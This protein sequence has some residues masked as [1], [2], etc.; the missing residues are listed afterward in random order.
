MY[1]AFPFDC[2]DRQ[3]EH[4]LDSVDWFNVEGDLDD[5]IFFD[6]AGVSSEPSSR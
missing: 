3:P 1:S 5:F 2:D 6:P 4:N